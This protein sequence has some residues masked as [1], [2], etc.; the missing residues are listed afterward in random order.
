MKMIRCMCAL[1]H[2]EKVRERGRQR[3]K[4][5]REETTEGNGQMVGQTVRRDG[6]TIR[7]IMVRSRQVVVTH[8]MKGLCRLSKGFFQVGG[9]GEGSQ[10]E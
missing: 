10:F 6:E 3:G 7:D 8:G 9:G 2:K 1:P 4:G 5:G